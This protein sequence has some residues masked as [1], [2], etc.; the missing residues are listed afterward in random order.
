MDF[1]SLTRKELQSLCKLNKIPANIT[2][3]AMADALQSLDIVEGIEKFIEVT[4]SETT[5]LNGSKEN[6]EEISSPKAP[7]TRCRTTTRKNVKTTERENIEPTDTRTTRRTTKKLA[8]GGEESK[9]NA[10]ETPAFPISQLNDCELESKEDHKSTV[11]KSRRNLTTASTTVKK[12]STLQK[13]YITRRSTKQTENKSGEP[14]VKKESEKAVVINSMLDEMNVASDKVSAVEIPEIT[15]NA[16]IEIEDICNAFEDVDIISEEKEEINQKPSSDE[17]TNPDENPCENGDLEEHQD[18]ILDDKSRIESGCDD[19]IQVDATVPCNT[20]RLNESPDLEMNTE[21]SIDDEICKGKMDDETLT[22]NDDNVEQEAKVEDFEK[23][24]VLV[25]A[26]KIEEK[27]DD[28]DNLNLESDECEKQ[29]P[30]EELVQEE[31]HSESF[32]DDIALIESGDN[33][34]NPKH[35]GLNVE[36][37]KDEGSDSTVPENTQISSPSD[38]NM[39][40][41]FVISQQD[42]D[43]TLDVTSAIDV[44][45]DK[46]NNGVLF[47]NKTKKEKGAIVIKSYED[48]SLRQLKKQFKALNLKASNNQNVVA[49]KE[50]RPALQALCENQIVGG[51]ETNI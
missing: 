48:F 20:E 31:E 22:L 43:E 34:E 33:H 39:G 27:E 41:I 5:D 10:L 26:H 16:D 44:T 7:K 2:N 1:H 50:S 36:N 24:D 29:K 46:E 12:Q 37:T 51:S 45:D 47:G 14:R 49:S 30:C 23:L 32:L 28:V 11:T 40:G 42:D 13:A 18:S 19:I 38:E 8:E 3:V 17:I 4:Q 35:G 6:V 15:V 25:G 9:N 21:I